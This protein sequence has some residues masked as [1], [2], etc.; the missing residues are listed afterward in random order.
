MVWWD[1]SSASSCCYRLC[2][3]H[4]N[5]MAWDYPTSPCC[6]RLC[7]LHFS[8]MAWDYPTS[9][10]CYRLCLLHFSKMAWDPPPHIP[11]VIGYVSYTSVKWLSGTPAPTSFCYYRLCLLHFS[12]MAWDSPTSSCYYRLCLLHFNKVSSLDSPHLPVVIGYALYTSIKW[13]GGSSSPT[14]SCCFGICLLYVCNMV[15]VESSHLPVVCVKPSILQENGL[16]KR[17]SFS[18]SYSYFTFLPI[19]HH[20]RN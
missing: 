20:M 10:C 19:T 1:T 2:L 17:D 4:F 5:K 6:Y 14:S 16:V 18:H 7:L 13:L 15:W 11:V 3:L 9:S 8:K 12:K